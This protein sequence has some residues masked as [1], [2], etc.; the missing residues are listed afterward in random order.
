MN[1]DE[2]TSSTN[3]QVIFPDLEKNI[4]NGH[5]TYEMVDL[6]QKIQQKF[7]KHELQFWEFQETSTCLPEVV[8]AIGIKVIIFFFK[9]RYFRVL[10]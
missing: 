2:E 5:K 7:P 6:V 9:I 3:Q 4:D 1:E 10:C 8:V